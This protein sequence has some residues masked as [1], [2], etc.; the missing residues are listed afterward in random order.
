MDALLE[1]LSERFRRWNPETANDVRQRLIDIID[2]AVQDV[3]RSPAF[4][5]RWSNPSWIFWMNPHPQ[6][7]S[8]CTVAC[9]LVRAV[10][11][12]LSRLF[13]LDAKSREESPNS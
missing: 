8:V 11:T 13:A 10:S 4:S 1:E 3:P 9:A 5:R 2:L 12:I 6:Y 7:C